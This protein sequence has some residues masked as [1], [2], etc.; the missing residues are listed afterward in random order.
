MKNIFTAM[1]AFIAVI[2]YCCFSPVVSMAENTSVMIQ[3]SPVNGGQ[4]NLGTGVHQFDMNTEINLNA[5]AKPG[6]QFVYWLGDVSDTE[7]ANTMAYLNGPKI[8][9][10][11]FEHVEYSVLEEKMHKVTGTTVASTLHPDAVAPNQSQASAKASRKNQSASGTIFQESEFPVPIATCDD[12][13]FPV[14]TQ[15]VPEP[16]TGL[17]IILG[18]LITY[19]SRK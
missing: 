12:L 3:Q 1:T 8:I 9:I 10:A 6:Y 7:S 4:I 16:A 13:D 2:A 14:P 5:V 18:S 19:R 15:S 17:L 11:V